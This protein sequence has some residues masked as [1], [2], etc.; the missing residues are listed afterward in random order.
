MLFGIPLARLGTLCTAAVVPA[1]ARA[2]PS[3]AWIKISIVPCFWHLC[4]PKTLSVLMQQ[5]SDR[6]APVR[7]C[8]PGLAIQVEVAA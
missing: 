8:R 1:P 2:R 5:W 7:F 6:A 4:V 3:F